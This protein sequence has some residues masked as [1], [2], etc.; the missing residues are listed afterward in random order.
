MYFLNIIGWVVPPY[1]TSGY[2]RTLFIYVSNR[3]KF[4]N[5]FK[6]YFFVLDIKPLL[7]SNLDW[8]AAFVY[9]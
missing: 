5:I 8:K 4:V 3:D 6:W 2:E 7:L 1:F 9:H